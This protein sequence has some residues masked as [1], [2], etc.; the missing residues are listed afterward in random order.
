MI[1]TASIVSGTKWKIIAAA[2]AENAKPTVLE[3]VA[4]RKIAIDTAVQEGAWCASPAMSY[5]DPPEYQTAT[6][7]IALTSKPGAARPICRPN[8]A[9]AD[10][11]IPLAKG[12]L[13]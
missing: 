1:C 13:N 11:N 9:K 3:R 6:P 12:F 5:R 8:V 10:I 4:A 7:A 2:M